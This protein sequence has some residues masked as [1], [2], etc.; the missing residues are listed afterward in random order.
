MLKA[1]VDSRRL[2]SPL[3]CS[4]DSARCSWPTMEGLSD[5]LSEICSAHMWFF[6][7]THSSTETIDAASIIY[8]WIPC[9]PTRTEDRLDELAQLQRQQQRRLNLLFSS[10]YV[11]TDDR[12]HSAEHQEPTGSH[13]GVLGSRKYLC[14]CDAWPP[15]PAWVWQ[16]GRLQVG[17]SPRLWSRHKSRLYRHVFAWQRLQRFCF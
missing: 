14:Q 3:L 17:P 8:L 1:R 13:P 10:F 7:M 6:E 4:T 15:G 12:Y 2:L 5:S 11:L 16:E 9:D